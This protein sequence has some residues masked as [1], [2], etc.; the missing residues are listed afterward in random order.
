MSHITSHH[1]VH[2][3]LIIGS[4]RRCSRSKDKENE[5]Y[6]ISNLEGVISTERVHVEPI[7]SNLGQLSDTFSLQ[8]RTTGS[9]QV[10]T[11]SQCF[12][13]PEISTNY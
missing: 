9:T 2:K 7:V 11:G 12:G 4:R 1:A 5:H 3:G 8:S 10:T 6:E 13:N